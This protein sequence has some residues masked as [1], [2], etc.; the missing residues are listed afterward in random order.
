MIHI[1]PLGRKSCINR[2]RVQGILT[3]CQQTWKSLIF[4]QTK[5]VL[6]ILY[7]YKTTCVAIQS[8]VTSPG[9]P[10]HQVTHSQCMIN[11][12]DVRLRGQ[13]L[14]SWFASLGCSAATGLHWGSIQP[15]RHQS[16]QTH[17]FILDHPLAPTTLEIHLLAIYTTNHSVRDQNLKE[18]RLLWPVSPVHFLKV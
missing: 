14:G 9:I 4:L 1:V 10:Q 5:W 17:R 8:Q 12:T 13:L 3:F 7:Y 6:P 18:N 2:L 15:L 16:L 11:L